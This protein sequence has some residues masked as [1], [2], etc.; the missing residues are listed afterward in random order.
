M[1]ARRGPPVRGPCSFFVFFLPSRNRE[2]GRP[3]LPPWLVR[4][5]ALPAWASGR[6]GSGRPGLEE[7]HQGLE[8]G[9][10]W[11]R[12]SQRLRALRGA[13]LGEGRRGRRGEDSRGGPPAWSEDLRIG[14]KE[15]EDDK[16]GPA[17]H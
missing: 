15:E 2:A 10:G 16:V 13:G 9:G 6:G 1:A 14:W 11:R 5:E 17:C 12:G 3:L 4:G 8:R 7:R